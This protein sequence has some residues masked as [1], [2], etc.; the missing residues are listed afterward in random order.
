MKTYIVTSAVNLSTLNKPF[1][2]SILQFKKHNNAEVRVV[3]IRYK[4]PTSKSE[5][6]KARELDKYAPELT[7]YLTRREERLGPNLTLFADIPA[8]PT[9]SNVLSGL[10]V[11]AAETSGIVGHVKRQ[12]QV[13]PTDHEIPRV[14]WTTGACT[15]PNYSKTRAGARA[16]KH[17]VFGALIVKVVGK[18]FYVRNVTANNDGSFSDLAEKY[19]PTGVEQN[20]AAESVTAGDIHVGQEDP[21]SLEALE[22]LVRM[23]QPRWLVLH[24]VLDFHARSHHRRDR[25]SMYAS[26]FDTVKAELNSNA[27]FLKQVRPWGQERTAIVASNHHD[28]LTRWLEE[29][30]PATDPVNAPEYHALWTMLYIYRDDTGG[31]P[32]TYEMAMR[33]RDVPDDYVFLGRDQSLKV[34]GVEHRYHGDKGPGGARGSIRAF[35]KLGVKVNIG[36]SHSPGILDGVFQTGSTCRTDLEY[37]SGQPRTHLQAHIVTHADG[38]RQL[39]VV[40]RGKFDA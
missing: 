4:N 24:D 30:D 5:A 12:M 3:A 22:E 23:M 20:D 21:A 36:H 11:Y 37:T 25:R 38:K 19:T 28:H 8:Q 32:D 15:M 40:V 2:A 13:I 26:R 7:S 35:S 9:A 27:A 17:H 33:A 29:F 1:W 31:W 18:R 34:G 16:K 14:L 10:E 6:R 39:I